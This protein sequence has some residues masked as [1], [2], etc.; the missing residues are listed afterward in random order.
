MMMDKI[1]YDELAWFSGDHLCLKQLQNGVFIQCY[2]ICSLVRSKIAFW[3]ACTSSVFSFSWFLKDFTSSMSLQ[4]SSIWEFPSISLILFGETDSQTST[5]ALL[6]VECSLK[7][8]N[9]FRTLIGVSILLPSVPTADINNDFCGLPYES[10]TEK[11]KTPSVKH[12]SLLTTFV[13]DRPYLSKQ[14]FQFL[15]C[16]VSIIA[17]LK[18]HKSCTSVAFGPRYLLYCTNIE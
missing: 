1:K 15:K 8:L 6:G 2:H 9:I 16:F 12:P 17:G 13:H 3:K 7:I 11:M 10:Y 18:Y 5:E 14:T 4:Q